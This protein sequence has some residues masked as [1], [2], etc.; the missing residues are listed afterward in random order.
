MKLENIEFMDE[1]SRKAIEA[2]PGKVV[3]VDVKGW[4]SCIKDPMG[5]ERDFVQVYIQKGLCS[6]DAPKGSTNFRA[7]FVENPYANFVYAGV[8]YLFCSRSY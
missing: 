8:E 4:A 5:S 7:T 3:D 1:M 6:V 2:L